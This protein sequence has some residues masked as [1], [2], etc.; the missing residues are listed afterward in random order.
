MNRREFIARSAVLASSFATGWAAGRASAD[1]ALGLQLFTVLT[2][3]EQDFDGTLQRIARI[4]YREVETIGALGRD[5]REVRAALD[6][7]GLVTPSQHLM[8]GDLYGN[9]LRFARREISEQDVQKAWNELMSVERMEP[10]VEEAIERAR[11]LGQR[12]IV[13]QIIWPHQ[14]A[15]R[16]ALR[17]FC[18]ALDLAG[19]LCAKAGLVFN[20]HNHADEMRVVDGRVPY[21][22]ILAETNPEKVR[23]ELDVYWAVRAGVDPVSLLER[24]GGRYVQCHLKDSAANG[25][26]A[27][28][29]RGVIDFPRIL[30]AARAA[31]VVHHYVE[32]DRADDPMTVVRE[33]YDYLAPLV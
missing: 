16:A 23:L 3:L 10:V 20:F 30:R 33:A 8:A 4:G 22:V 18:L 9:F 5:P 19:E 21:D 24:H 28:V 26:F 15:N 2:A 1:R 25:D 7:V 29:G 11:I 13:L 17:D 6:R 27:T 31:G 12:H 32:Y 14:M